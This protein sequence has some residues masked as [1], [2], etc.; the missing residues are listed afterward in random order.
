MGHLAGQPGLDMVEFTYVG[1]RHTPIHESWYDRLRF[2]FSNDTFA[3]KDQMILTTLQAQTQMEM[4]L[5]VIALNRYRLRTGHFP[6]ELTALVPDY[7]HQLPHDYM[8]GKSSSLQIANKRKFLR[9]ITSGWMRKDDGGDP[10]PNARLKNAQQNSGSV[11][12]RCMAYSR[13]K[14]NK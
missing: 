11:G 10:I 14:T 12:T 9:F 8:D 1:L 6:G 2:L 7:L 13:V 5:T 3:I 4:V